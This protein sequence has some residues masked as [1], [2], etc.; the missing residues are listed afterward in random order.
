MER[1][2]LE[3]TRKKKGTR[4]PREMSITVSHITSDNPGKTLVT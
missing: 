4:R 1:N 3:D 2:V